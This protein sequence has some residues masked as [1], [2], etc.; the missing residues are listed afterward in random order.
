MKAVI[1]DRYGPPDVLRLQDVERPVPGPGEVLQVRRD[2]Q[3][4]GNVVLAVG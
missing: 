2:R 1:C 4:T 3:K